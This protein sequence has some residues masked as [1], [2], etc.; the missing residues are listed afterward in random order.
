MKDYKVETKPTY[1]KVKLSSGCYSDYNEEH[2]FF[3]GND[4]DEIWNFLCRYI[5]D[6]TKENSEYLFG[7]SLGDPMAMKYKDK[8]YISEK[9]NGDEEDVRWGGNYEITN[10]DIERLNVIYFNK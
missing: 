2:L 8:K 4:E 6:I 7:L 5:E 3:A 1:W 10:V 9:Y